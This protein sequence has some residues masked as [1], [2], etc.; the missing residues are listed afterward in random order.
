MKQLIKF[1]FAIM[2]LAGVG[3]PQQTF[4]SGYEEYVYSNAYDGYT[5]IR[6]NPST[7]GKIIGVLPNGNYPA[8][9]IEVSWE[10][11]NWYY[12]YYKGIYGY[13]AK[14]QMS[15][16]PQNAVNLKI[17]AKWLTGEWYDRAGNK[18]TLDNKGNFTLYG[19][20]E[21]AGKWRLTGGNNLT[22]K[23]TYAG[24]SQTLAVDLDLGCVGDFTRAGARLPLSRQAAINT[25]GMSD[26]T[27]SQAIYR[28]SA[29]ALPTEYQ[30]IKGDWTSMLNPQNKLEINDDYITINSIMGG[31]KSGKEVEY[32]ISYHFNNTFKKHYVAIKPNADLPIVYL[33][34]I[35]HKIFFLNQF[36]EE[37]FVKS[38][39]ANQS[40]NSGGGNGTLIAILG[41]VF[42]A[43]I[44]VVVFLVMKL[45]SQ[46]Q[47]QK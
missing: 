45:K 31:E 33:D 36:A 22:L 25:A 28:S 15:S 47:T 26:Y 32:T 17:T 16:T 35:D 29:D 23:A 1:A 21:A 18:L 39:E 13:V 20:T 46:K 2:L 24:W 8:E 30:W 42:G 10:N 19:T 5:N 12:I 37:E 38:G 41:V 9:F 7:K 34:T 6:N 44:A 14:S 3:V 40:D 27:L 43:L 4:A 11:N